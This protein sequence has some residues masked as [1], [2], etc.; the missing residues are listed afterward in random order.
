MSRLHR[1]LVALSRQD[2]GNQ[3]FAPEALAALVASSEAL[4]IANELDALT[5]TQ[6]L[7]VALRALALDRDDATAQALELEFV[8]TLPG[9]SSSVARTTEV[10]IADLL[11]QAKHQV[12]VVGYELSEPSFI[13][14]LTA[15]SRRGI[16]LLCITDRRSGHGKRLL[17][18]WP[19]DLMP[20][21]VFQEKA[22]ELSKMAKMHGKALLVDGQALFLSSANFTWLGMNANI[23]L[24]VILRGPR[25]RQARVLFEELLVES[26]LLERV[27][28]G[29]RSSE[30]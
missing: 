25:I 14:A 1:Q 7:V 11:L 26:G 28:F 18:K 22:I 6:R 23:E 8:A 15:A 19:T 10:A 17:A 13:A 27:G 24:G 21:R 29:E 9:F 30:T 12:V 20:P 2:P 3:P 4:E 5:P 16:E